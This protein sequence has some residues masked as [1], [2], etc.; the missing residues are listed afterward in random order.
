M[1]Q[2]L[3]GLMGPMCPICPVARHSKTPLPKPAHNPSG[4]MQTQPRFTVVTFVLVALV[5]LAFVSKLLAPYIVAPTNARLGKEQATFLQEG[6]HE[7][8]NWYPIADRWFKF[9]RQ[10]D[11]PILLVVG[12]PWSQTGRRMDATIFSSP[13][14]QKVLDRNF[15]CI[16]VDALENPD[17]MAAYLPISR[18]AMA[19]P[20]DFQIWLLDSQARLF[21]PVALHA[22]DPTYGDSQFTDE[23]ADDLTKLQASL[24]AEFAGTTVPDEGGP[25]QS[26]DVDKLS[27]ASGSLVPNLSPYRDDLVS[28]SRR[29]PSGGFPVNQRQ[30]LW[31]DAWLFVLNSS[32]PTT[33][34]PS[35]A[36]LL[37]SPTRDML[38]GGFF[39]GSRDPE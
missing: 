13:T 8:V 9:A 30:R 29:R 21:T 12:A 15:I 26:L 2:P 25:I 4:L 16:R 20:S 14:V 33:A 36:S 38:D 24:A 18:A 22:S 1:P 23:L 19:I 10:K 39:F 34:E 28:Q 6:A 5:A 3:M 17:W 35:I 27:S 11:R 32:G 37:Q 7:H 31:P